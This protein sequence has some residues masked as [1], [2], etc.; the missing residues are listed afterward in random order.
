MCNYPM[1]RAET[2]ERYTNSKGGTSYKVDWLQR[3]QVDDAGGIQNLRKTFSGK[4]RKIELTP[5]GQCIPCMLAYSRDKAT[6]IMLEKNFGY[7][8]GNPYPDGTCWMITTTYKDEYLPSHKTFRT[9]TGEI[10]EGISLNV[11]HDQD[12]MKLLRYYY[13]NMKMKRVVAGEYGSLSGRPHYHSI[14]FGLPLD[15]TKFKTWNINKW[16]QRTWTLTDLDEIWGK[17]MVNIARVEW[18]NAAYVARYALKK[19]FKKDKNWYMAQGMLPEFIHWSNGIGKNFFLENY[20][21]IYKTDSVPIINNHG[22]IVKPPKSYDRMLKE[23]DEDLYYKIKSTRDKN[24][25]ISEKIINSSTDLT[26]EERRK[27]SE[28]RMQQVMKDI[29]LEV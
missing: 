4:Y 8:E 10:F 6:Q 20:E 19:A 17:G 25:I 2:F 1:V 3:S 15:V 27:V 22:D 23:I 7:E 9:D 28:A 5:C 11:K 29:R 21:N 14:I 12:F 18:Q 26:P 16:G 13:P 24:S